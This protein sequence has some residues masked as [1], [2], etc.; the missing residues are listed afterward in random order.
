MYYCVNMDSTLLE[1]CTRELELRL[2]GFPGITSSIVRIIDLYSE[3]QVCIVELSSGT[4]A[5][6]NR[7]A[8]K[9]IEG[10]QRAFRTFYYCTTLNTPRNTP[11]CLR[12]HDV[13]WRQR[14][15]CIRIGNNDDDDT[16][17][18]HTQQQVDNGTTLVPLH[19]RDTPTDADYFS[20]SGTKSFWNQRFTEETTSRASKRR[21]VTP[22][23]SQHDANRT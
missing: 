6:V 11:T 3:S 10:G 12:L 14:A 23:T 5:C 16:F 1:A 2:R 8:L 4:L 19:C 17:H 21:N 13:Q 9:N 18:S 7:S 15:G 20:T 22:I